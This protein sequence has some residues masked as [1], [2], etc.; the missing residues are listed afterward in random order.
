MLRETGV[1]RTRLAY[2]LA[3]PLRGEGRVRGTHGDSRRSQ[4]KERWF[5]HELKQP[6]ATEN[7]IGIE[8]MAFAVKPAT[9]GA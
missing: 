2:S 6:L 5:F 8:R 1:A 7:K 3:P 4:D 9:P